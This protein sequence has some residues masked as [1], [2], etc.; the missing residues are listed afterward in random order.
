MKQ[1]NPVYGLILALAGFAAIVFDK[2]ATVTVD[3]AS[4]LLII[5][6][7]IILVG[8][9][10]VSKILA[11]IDNSTSFLR[12]HLSSSNTSASR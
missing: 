3:N 12:S 11:T 10:E 5:V 2:T 4:Y 1:F 9:H 6:G 7:L 8:S